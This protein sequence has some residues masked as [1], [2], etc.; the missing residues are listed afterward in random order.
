MIL[1]DVNVLVHAHNADSAV[2]DRAMLWWAPVSREPKVWSGLGD[3]ARGH[4]F[5]DQ[6][7]G[8]GAERAKSIK[9]QF[10]ELTHDARA[11]Y[12]FPASTQGLHNE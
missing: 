6:P 10:R 1:L 5:H 3:N 9:R 12:A 2:H 4:A 11:G 7:H 8:A